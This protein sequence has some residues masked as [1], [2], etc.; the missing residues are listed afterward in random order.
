MDIP[1]NFDHN[2]YNNLGQLLLWTFLKTTFTFTISLMPEITS[3]E[4]L[5]LWSKILLKISQE[6][7][8]ANFITWFRNTAI[9]S[10]DDETG[11]LIIGAPTPFAQTQLQR[12]FQLETFRAAKEVLPNATKVMFEIDAALNYGKSSQ[13]VDVQALLSGKAPKKKKGLK[14]NPIQTRISRSNSDDNDYHMLNPKYTLDNFIVGDEYRLAFAAA[15]A[16]IQN[17]GTVYNP[18]FIYGGVGLGKTHLLQAIGNALLVD[19]K[20][21]HKVIYTTSE[22]LTNEFINAMR[23][24]RGSQFKFTYRSADCLIIDDVQFLANK[25]QTQI[26]VFHTFNTLYEMGK[27]IVLSSDRPPREIKALEER[28]RSRFEMGMIADIQSPS[29]ETKLAILR[30]KSQDIGHLLPAETLEYVAEHAGSNV[31]EIEGILTQIVAHIELTNE[32]PTIGSVKEILK[33]S[34]SNYV[35]KSVPNNKPISH[36]DVITCVADHFDL[37]QADLLGTV[38]KKEIVV[39][40]QVCMY[41]IRKDLSYSYEKIGEVFGGRNHTTVMHAFTKVNRELKTDK[42]LIKH[43]SS[44]RRDLNI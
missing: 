11:I 4:R 10:W 25:V 5:A 31:R 43:I 41:I 21:K 28:L 33:K 16:V 32:Q 20:N 9:Q 37:S 13:V 26:E 1:R 30:A 35:E 42:N 22:A 8:R 39:P 44:L 38:R 19:K 7:N 34:S 24:R 6:I 36:E 18:L 2:G 23:N 12:K 27:Q 14:N 17:P 29:Y 40:R 15:K 3:E